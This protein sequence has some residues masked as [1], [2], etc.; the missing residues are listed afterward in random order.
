MYKYI[1]IY[2]YRQLANETTLMNNEAHAIYYAGMVRERK[3]QGGVLFR[4]RVGT[5]IT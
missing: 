4:V 1:N 3:E 5:N 2:I